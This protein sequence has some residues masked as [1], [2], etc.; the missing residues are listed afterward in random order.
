[1]NINGADAS[2]FVAESP[3]ALC[4]PSRTQDGQALIDV[5]NSATVFVNLSVMGT[6]ILSA[7]PCVFSLLA[8]PDYSVY[9][10]YSKTPKAWFQVDNAIRFANLRG[11]KVR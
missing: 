3:P 7:P 5:L 8:S 1:M 11:V 4:A 6:K 9:Y 2:V 10:L